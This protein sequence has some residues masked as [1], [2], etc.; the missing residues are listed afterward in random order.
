MQPTLQSSDPCCQNPFRIDLRSLSCFRI[1]IA[2]VL[3]YDVFF[4]VADLSA[5][6]LAGGA[7]PV[8]TVREYHQGNWSWSLHML[9]DA[10]AWQWLLCTLRLLAGLALLAGV[11]SQLAAGIA[12][13]LTVSMHTRAPMLV[14]GG[15]VL[16]A[17][18]LLHLIQ[19][20][21]VFEHA[22][23]EAENAGQISPEPGFR[24]FMLLLNVCP[25]CFQGLI[26]PFLFSLNLIRP[27]RSPRDRPVLGV[28]HQRAGDRDTW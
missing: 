1:A 8:E 12:W 6:Y 23:M 14:T 5:L 2:L 21:R 26:E 19:D 24:L 4:Q 17:N 18:H 13:L 28:D 9:W 16:L 7:L 15:D 10:T 25:R 20:V 22:Q 27:D 3:V 11:R